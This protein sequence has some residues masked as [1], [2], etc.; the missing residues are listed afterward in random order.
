MQKFVQTALALCLLI[1][2]SPAAMA[3]DTSTL[4]WKSPYPTG[5][6]MSTS[7]QGGG[8]HCYATVRGHSDAHG[9]MA[10]F[11]NLME[12]E[13][14]PWQHISNYVSLSYPLD[15]PV[16]NMKGIREAHHVKIKNGRII[17]F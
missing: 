11:Y 5:T 9:K 17:L 6:I 8:G 7:A 12:C 3:K 16:I 2:L 4:L 14:E 10:R 13:T 1:T 15:V